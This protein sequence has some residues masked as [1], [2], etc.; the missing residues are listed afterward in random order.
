MPAN[1]NDQTIQSSN[2]TIGHLVLSSGMFLEPS[3][4]GMNTNHTSQPAGGVNGGSAAVV[5]SGASTLPRAESTLFRAGQQ[6]QQQQSMSL[7]ANP[8]VWMNT[9]SKKN[10]TA[11]GSL[12]MQQQQSSSRYNLAQIDANIQIQQ[13]LQQLQIRFFKGELLRRTMSNE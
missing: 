2:S 12:V 6:L 8:N 11:V 5:N 3:M 4:V 13:Q 9:L 7:N 10:S 1:L